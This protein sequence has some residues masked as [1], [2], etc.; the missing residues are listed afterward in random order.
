[1]SD[2]ISRI[3]PAAVEMDWQPQRAPRDWKGMAVWGGLSL[4]MALLLLVQYAWYSFDDLAR[5]E[6]YRSSFASVCGMV[7]CELPSQFNPM[8]VRSSNLV[9]RSHPTLNNVLVVD[10]IIRNSAQ[11]SQPFPHLELYFTDLNQFP[12]ASGRFTARDYLAGELAGKTM[13]PPGKSVHISME[14]VDPGPEA[15]NY[16]IQISP[17]DPLEG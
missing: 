15:V 1:M 5:D 4:A 17:R 16:R 12:V 7:G 2:I 10:A 6:R 11:Y 8:A 13:M 9:V 3:E 14:I